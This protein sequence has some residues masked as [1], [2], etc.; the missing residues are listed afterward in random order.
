MV[1]IIWSI[2]WPP[3]NKDF[4]EI[5]EDFKITMNVSKFLVFGQKDRKLIFRAVQRLLVNKGSNLLSG[6]CSILSLLMQLMK[7]QLP[8]QLLFQILF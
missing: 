1:H 3:Y 7:M 8:V 6:Y 2:I 5:F 4:S